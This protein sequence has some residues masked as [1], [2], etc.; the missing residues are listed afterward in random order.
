M[1]IVDVIVVVIV[2]CLIIRRPPR[3]TRT[4]TL[5]PYTTL[6]RSAATPRDR[7]PPVRASRASA[8]RNLRFAFRSEEHTSELQ[9][10]MR[11]SYAV[12]CLKKKNN[13]SQPVLNTNKTVPKLE[14]NLLGQT[15]FTLHTQHKM[16]D[17]P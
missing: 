7:A 4:D 17:N 9:S 16:A 15:Q 14:A 5:F 1:C 8:Q 10:L 3:S 12:F 13:H 11:N 6:F 2:F